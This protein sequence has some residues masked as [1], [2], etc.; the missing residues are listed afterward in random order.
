M[1]TV[2]L[3]SVFA[4]AFISA[5]LLLRW[6]LAEWCIIPLAQAYER[7]EAQGPADF[8]PCS[9][10]KAF[11][12]LNKKSGPELA[13][14]LLK[15][16]CPCRM[17]LLAVYAPGLGMS[18][19]EA[20]ETQL[21]LAQ[22][23]DLQHMCGAA[24][25]GLVLL[26]A[27]EDRELINEPVRGVTAKAKEDA[28]RAFVHDFAE[29]WGSV[30]CK[31]ILGCDLETRE[32]RERAEAQRLTE[33]LCPQIMQETAELTTKLSGSGHWLRTEHRTLHKDV[34]LHLGET[35]IWYRRA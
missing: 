30:Y 33:S 9:V 22:R 35:T 2:M 34:G 10:G 19:G 14:L 31:D 3:T 18:R 5:L 17:A 29:R 11:P 4:A 20:F 6:A 28:K 21:R 32:G 15:R 26:Q 8:W 25:C 16:G 23:M 24:A 27:Q 12:D 13:A 7:C 1:T